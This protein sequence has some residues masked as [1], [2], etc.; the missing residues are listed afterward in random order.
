MISAFSLPSRTAKMAAWTGPFIG[1]RRFQIVDLQATVFR[2]RGCCTNFDEIRN[3]V[4]FYPL[5]TSTLGKSLACPT[6]T[7]RLNSFPERA[8]SSGIAD[9]SIYNSFVMVV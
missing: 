5:T 4:I 9:S 8:H 7:H 1:N 2:L 3:I 6:V